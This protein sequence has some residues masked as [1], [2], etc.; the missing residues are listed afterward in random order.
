LPPAQ[1]CPALHTGPPPQLHAPP[2]E[3]ESARAVSQPTHTA[4]PLPQAATDGVLQVLPEQQPLGQ[5]VA[6]HPL[7]TPPVHTCPAGH[8]PHAA[9]PAPH[10]AAVVPATHAP[11][12]QH[13]LGHDV[14][15]HT[16]VLATQRWP[17]AQATPLPHRQVPVAEQLSDRMS[18]ATQVDPASPQLPGARARQ[19]APLQ[20]PLGHDIESHT[21]APPLQR[22][23]AT[24]AA[25]TPHA[26]DPSAPQW[27]ALLPSHATHAAPLAPQVASAGVLHT[28]PV[29][30]PVAHDVAS[31]T[32]APPLQ[33]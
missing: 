3:Q 8:T 15:S 20:Q 13:P 10:D 11:L 33:R 32:H 18:H 27:S 26:H 7:H 31:H 21:H 2:A 23:P 29:Q 1:R 9:P 14:P 12:A 4:P 28:P 24:H 30:Q 6:L 19:V 22:W 16:Q 5:L 17:A 25:P